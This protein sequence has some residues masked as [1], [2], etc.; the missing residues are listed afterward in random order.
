[1]NSAVLLSIIL[2]MGKFCIENNTNI[3]QKGKPQTEKNLLKL[4]S[5]SFV[6]CRLPNLINSTL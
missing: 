2:L 3:R 1:M 5:Y 6:V 4:T